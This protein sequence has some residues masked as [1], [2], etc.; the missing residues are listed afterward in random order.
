M[1][2]LH[3]IHVGINTENEEEADVHQLQAQHGVNSFLALSGDLSP[4]VYKRQTPSCN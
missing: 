1:L 3:L 4:D 2:G